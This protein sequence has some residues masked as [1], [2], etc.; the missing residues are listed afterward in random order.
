MLARM[1]DAAA[2]N[3]GTLAFLRPARCL[4]LRGTPLPM[5]RECRESMLAATDGDVRTFIRGC[6]EWPWQLEVDLEEEREFRQ[7]DVRYRPGNYATRVRLEVSSNGQE[8][9]TV[10]EA[11]N[12]N[13]NGTGL[14]FAPVRAR[15]LRYAALKPDGEGQLGEQMGI[16]EISVR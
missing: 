13:T 10:A 4:S 16:A 14:V 9:R 3:R 7:V 5:Q 15:Y 11:D 1:R 2:R 8:W 6:M 12:A